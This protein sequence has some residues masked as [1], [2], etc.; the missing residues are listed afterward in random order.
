MSL[1]R[2]ATLALFAGAALA[3]M[4]ALAA[5]ALMNAA[6][7]PLRQTALDDSIRA[8][9]AKHAVPGA[10]LALIN[11][12]RIAYLRHY[13]VEDV[14]TGA[15]VSGATV[16]EAASLS[17]PVFSEMVMAFVQSG[18]LSLD[19]PLAGILP[20]EGLS[21]PRAAKITARM[22]LTHTTGLPNW[23]R[24]NKSGALDLAFDPGAGF[25]YSGEGFEYLARVMQRMDGVDARG[26]ERMFQRMIARPAGLKRSQFVLTP[27]LAAK[28]AQPHRNGKKIAFEV[29]APGQFGAAYALHTT[30]DDY[31]KWLVSVMRGPSP[32]TPEARDLWLSPQNAPI[33]A[34]HPDRAFG[35]SDWA[36]GFQIFQ[37]PFGRLHMHGGSNQGFTCLA[38]ARFDAGW[39]FAV[40]T[41]ADQAVGF[42]RDLVPLLMGLARG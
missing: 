27:T 5:P 3:P 30:A 2:R 7:G 11:N 12:Q 4:P 17:K 34:N 9:M 28:R 39:G 32:L 41:N 18:R 25:R 38:G 1:S 20:L 14:D 8:A 40:F 19:A 37:L 29:G 15:K 35:L 10:S 16:F 33:P 22:V 36:L 26:L 31:A 24:E 21:D 42:L 6:G 23:R 13:G